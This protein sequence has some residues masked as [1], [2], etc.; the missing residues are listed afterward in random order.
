MV[1]RGPRKAL[2]ALQ[3]DTR[4]SGP[5]HLKYHIKKISP[6]LLV[7]LDV[8]ICYYSLWASKIM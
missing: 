8:T 6:L 2:L 1:P 4:S 3:I 5:Q 7:K